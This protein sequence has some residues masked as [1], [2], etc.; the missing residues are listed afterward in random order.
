MTNK[1]TLTYILDWIFRIWTGATILWTI[2]SYFNIMP[3]YQVQLIKVNTVTP[4][5]SYLPG[6]QIRL[7]IDNHDN[8]SK[9]EISS[10]KWS[11]KNGQQNHFEVEGLEPTITTPPDSGL[12]VLK[13]AVTML[14]GE[15][16][17]GQSVIYIVQDKPIA[18]K[19]KKSVQLMITSNNMNPAT[20][21]RYSPGILSKFI[22]VMERG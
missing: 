13:V 14:D 9:N 20:I 22:L 17:F 6:T 15:V 2:L 21:R 4:T 11:F 7:G 18:I 12:Y 1:Y 5:F 19:L 8:S 3:I 10:V 16:K